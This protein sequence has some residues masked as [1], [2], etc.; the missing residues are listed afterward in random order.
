MSRGL[1]NVY[2]EEMEGYMTLVEMASRY[3][4]KSADGLRRQAI[5]GKLKA[6][7]VG[8]GR[9]AVWVVRE[10]DA[11]HYAAE[12]LGKRGFASAEHPH[13]GTRPRRQE[14]HEDSESGIVS[15]DPTPRSGHD[16]TERG[17]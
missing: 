8:T 17:K 12:H 5:L 1:V 16:D 7:K 11:E 6:T 9:H 4:L 15:D 14:P 2:Y 10:E 3:G 13:F